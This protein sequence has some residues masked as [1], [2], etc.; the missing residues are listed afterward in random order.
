MSEENRSTSLTYIHNVLHHT[1]QRI[2]ELIPASK[3]VSLKL[4]QGMSPYKSEPLKRHVSYVR[5]LLMMSEYATSIGSRI[6]DMVIKHILDI[7]V[8]LENHFLMSSV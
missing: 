5:T 1:I 3:D 7:D 2:M 8:S 6:W 4:L